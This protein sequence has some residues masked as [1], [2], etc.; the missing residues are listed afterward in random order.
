MGEKMSEDNY[1]IVEFDDGV[2]EYIVEYFVNSSKKHL[3]VPPVLDSQRNVDRE[4]TKIAIQRAIRD[5]QARVKKTAAVGAN[6]LVGLSDSIDDS[7]I[8]DDSNFPLGTPEQ[9]EEI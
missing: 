8:E 7:A 1:R 3:R 6:L 2:D 4:L 9:A 5:E